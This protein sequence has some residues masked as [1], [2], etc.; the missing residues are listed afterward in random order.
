[1]AK[2]NRDETMVD[3]RIVYW[4]SKEAGKTTNLQSVYRK[5]RPDHRG[6][7]EREPTRIDPTVEFEQLPIELGEVGGLR[8][9]IQMVAVPGGS[10]QAPTRKQL[11]DQVD[12]I[13]LVVDSRREC[14][15]E[16][17]ASLDELRAF[18][19]EYGRTIEEVPLVIQYNKRDLTDPYAI[20]ELH[21]RLDVRNAAVFEAVATEA[22]G[23]LQTLSTLAKHVIRSL[24]G[25]Q[26]AMNSEPLQQPERGEESLADPSTPETID[27]DEVESRSD[28]S[29]S[30]IHQAVFE[31]PKTPSER[32]E[33]A[34]LSEDGHP[35][36]I[37]IGD[38]AR[39]AQTVFDTPWEDASAPCAEPTPG[40]SDTEFSIASV[41]EAT[42][43][44]ERG[45]RIPLVIAGKDD[46]RATV[47]LTIQLDLP[48][49]R[50]SD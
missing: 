49:V 15:E 6:E 11:L 13:V 23:V 10:N 28:P 17:V 18:L 19:G 46:Q 16:T 34:I 41:G 35:D 21:R 37:A 8:T 2:L 26:F 7:I 43:A 20:E 30:E 14:L 50:G 36:I 4:G 33:E 32:M 29:A 3:A 5:L 31:S 39:E 44:G 48:P 9:R 22:T 45:V 47:V 1:M 40:Q 25:R 12:G 38:L 42:R 24:R 27:A